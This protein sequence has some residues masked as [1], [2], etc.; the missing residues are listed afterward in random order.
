LQLLTNALLSDATKAEVKSPEVGRRHEECKKHLQGNRLSTRMNYH[1]VNF[2]KMY[3]TSLQYDSCCMFISN[4]V[5][6]STC[7]S[8]TM[9]VK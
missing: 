7:L 3:L 6:S 4:R 9:W 8:A 5:F 2:S 1:L